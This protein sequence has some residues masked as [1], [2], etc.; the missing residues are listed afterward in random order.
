M[1]SLL[2]LSLD[3]AN[4][5]TIEESWEMISDKEVEDIKQS[6]QNETLDSGAQK[7]KEFLEKLD[8]T[9]LNI[10]VTGMSGKGKS[11]FVNAIRGLGDEDEGSAP[12]GV[13]ETTMKATPYHHQKYPNVTLWDLPGIGTEN[14]RADEYL[15]KVEFHR[16]DFFIIISSERFT[17]YDADLAKEIQ[18][19]GKM[20]YFVRSKIDE[21]LR[22][23]ARKKTF[24]EKATLNK[25]QQNCITGLQDLSI[26]SPKVFLISSF[27]L[28]KYD[29]PQLQETLE[30]DLPQQKRHVFLLALPNITQNINLKK[31]EVLQA[32]IWR[33][34]LLSATAAAVPVPGLGFAA[35][36]TILVKEISKYYKAFGLDEASLKN[37]SERVNVPVEELKKAM[38][39]KYNENITTNMIIKMLTKVAG[40]GLQLTGYFLS[41]IPIIGSLPAGGIAFGT[42]YRMLHSCLDELAENAHLVLL[43][44]FSSPV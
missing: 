6:L 32:D 30:K 24:N 11:T 27:E 28:E 18:N 43:R 4:E 42:T 36:L 3:S 12:T 26:E 15:E 33:M 29:F 19:M 44:A 38:K 2:K 7:I 37:L 25:I 10:A 39:Y 13:V 40:G 21:S 1:E 17:S 16:Y 35:D 14:F 22:A 20:C 23:E 9:V 41:T 31:K 8:K 34:A 5:E